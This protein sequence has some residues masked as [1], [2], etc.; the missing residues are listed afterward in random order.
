M[1]AVVPDPSTIAKRRHL[2]RTGVRAFA[3]VLIVHSL[4]GANDVLAEY[5]TTEPD[6]A[7]YLGWD[8]IVREVLIHGV[9]IALAAI[10]LVIERPLCRWLVP[11]PKVRCPGCE[12]TLDGTPPGRCPECGLQLDPAHFGGYAGVMP[13]PK[14]EL[15]QNPPSATSPPSSLTPSV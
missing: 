11:M 3:L 14:R 2:L 10:L 9:P 5:L 1:D 12:Y 13:T 7:Q 8:L 6:Y 15:Q 4:L